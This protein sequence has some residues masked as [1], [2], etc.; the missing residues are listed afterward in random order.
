MSSTDVDT[1]G[2]GSAA[3]QQVALR[4][5]GMRCAG[6]AGK[7]QKKF[8]ELDGVEGA[9]V[10]LPLAEVELGLS[11]PL[12]GAQL[13][14]QV[15]Q[16]GFTTTRKSFL[17]EGID[18]AT[19]SQA[20]ASLPEFLGIEAKGE[21]LEARFLAPGPSRRRLR[22]RLGESV[23]IHEGK[24]ADLGPVERTRAEMREYGTRLLQA[25]AL[26]V[27]AV[28]LT[29]TSLFEALPLV[30]RQGLAFVLTGLLLLYPARVFFTVAWRS[31]RH[32]SAEMN[33]LIAAQHGD[34]VRARALRLHDGALRRHRARALLP[35]RRCDDLGARAARALAR[36]AGA[37]RGRQRRRGARRAHAQDRARRCGQAGGRDPDR[38]GAR[39]RRVPRAPG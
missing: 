1:Q 10:Q 32:G 21:L 31:L 6:C 29:M 4:V 14:A 20:L 36:G 8:L 23:A 11:G 2:T 17:L 19:A 30:A 34:G 22:E 15:E 7:V 39:G 37:A 28:L 13:E 35:R 25:L 3:G 5:L 27:P 18:E 33:T 9:H 12:T 26:G 16:A 24:S 38:G